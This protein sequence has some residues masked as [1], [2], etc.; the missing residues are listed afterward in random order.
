MK[1]F[2]VNVDFIQQDID[3]VIRLTLFSVQQQYID[4]Y[5]TNIK[6]QDNRWKLFEILGFDLL[7][8]EILK[9]WLLKVN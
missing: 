9:F 6:V 2:D 5:K 4:S 8:D 1:S 3:D 7:I